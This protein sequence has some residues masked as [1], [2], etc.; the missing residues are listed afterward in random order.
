MPSETPAT[1]TIG[2]VFSAPGGIYAD[3]VGRVPAGHPFVVGYVAPSGRIKAE[4]KAR[5]ISADEERSD[6]DELIGT[7]AK[8]KA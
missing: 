7:L 6:A 5:E 4:R 1:V 8:E 3:I 2:Q